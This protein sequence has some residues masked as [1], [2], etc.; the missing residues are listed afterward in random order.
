MTEVE[1]RI[2]NCWLATTRS[3]C[4][5]PFKLRKTW[6]GFEEKTDYRSIKKVASILNRYD[7]INM[8]IPNIGVVVPEI[9]IQENA[10]ERHLNNSRIVVNPN[11]EQTRYMIIVSYYKCIQLSIA[12]F[13]IFFI[14]LNFSISTVIIFCNLS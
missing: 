7:N 9:D 1:K 12:L 14:E 13:V 8:N 6:D 3:R 10:P 5:K 11:T 4:N 2:Y